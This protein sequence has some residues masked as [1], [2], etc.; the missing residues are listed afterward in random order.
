MIDCAGKVAVP[1][2]KRAGYIE[3]SGLLSE[4]ATPN[5]NLASRTDTLDVSFEPALRFFR[6]A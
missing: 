1:L 6:H 2:A 4:R 3:A 5:L